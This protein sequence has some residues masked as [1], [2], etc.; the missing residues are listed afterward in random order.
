[1]ALPPESTSVYEVLKTVEAIE[2]RSHVAVSIFC[3]AE[4]MAFGRDLHS[5]AEP[6]SLL[7]RKDVL[8]LFRLYSQ[9]VLIADKFFLAS[10]PYFLAPEE[11][12]CVRALC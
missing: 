4:F 10:F 6:R 11:D 1:M 7:Q 3:Q 9:G 2:D 5:L 12:I 8:H